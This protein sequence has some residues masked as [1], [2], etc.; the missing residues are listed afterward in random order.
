ME[1]Y[2]TISE[3][4]GLLTISVFVAGYIVGPL[5]WGPLSEIWGRRPVFI[6]AFFVYMCFQIGCA[7]AKN[8]GS[9]LVFRFISGCFAAAP[10]TTS[11]GVLADVWET[12]HRGQAMSVFA[13]APFAGPGE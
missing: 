2:F 3:E 10:L 4:V 9:I 7:L 8:T 5:F 1:E 13:L 12:N 11:G 6:I